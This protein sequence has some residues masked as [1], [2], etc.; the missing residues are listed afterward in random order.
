MQHDNTL[1]NNAVPPP[2]S[3]EHTQTLRI[4]VQELLPDDQCD[5]LGRIIDGGSIDFDGFMSLDE[6]MGW[7]CMSSVTVGTS[8]NYDYRDRDVFRPLQYCNGY[9]GIMQERRDAGWF[10]RGIV[11]M[12]SLH[13]EALVSRVSLTHKLPLG[14]AIREKVFLQ[15]V[16]SATWI[17]IDRFRHVYN[18]AKHDV[19]HP[20]DTHLFSC[21]D[22]VLA[23]FVCRAFGIKLRP[24]V[25]LHTEFRR[26]KMDD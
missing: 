10:T 12:S 7:A 6:S 20:K 18:A 25:E 8:G 22:A 23:Y 19:R 17:Q 16:D 13:V 15:K 21:E 1:M 24:L 2:I 3:C 5:E 11:H 14:R 26:E 9:F 4:L